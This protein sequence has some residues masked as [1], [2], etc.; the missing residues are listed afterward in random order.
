MKPG[1]TSCNARRLRY[2][3]GRWKTVGDVQPGTAGA[4]GKLIHTDRNRL[5][6]DCFLL[7]HSAGKSPVGRFEEMAVMG[8]DAPK[9]RFTYE[10]F[11][12][13]GERDSSTGTVSGS[14]W[15]W[16]ASVQRKGSR[17]VA[18]RYILEEISPTEYGFRFDVASG[19]KWR[20]VVEGRS[21][22]LR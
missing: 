16:R 8:Y 11:N 15:T 13:L 10:A 5:L 14:T 2:F 21:I 3:V 6:G 7:M 12:S 4:G 20:N 1:K 19:G 22:K 17:K 18:G 9:K